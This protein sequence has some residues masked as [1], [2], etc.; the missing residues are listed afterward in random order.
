M[1]Q[2]I[3]EFI[4]NLVIYDYIL[5]GATFFLFILLIVLAI[6]LRGK[7]ALAMLSIL[8]AF[9][10]LILAPTLGYTQMHTFLYK[11]EAQIDSIKKLEFTPA[12]VINGTYTNHSNF[13]FTTCK[14]KAKVFKVATNEML[15]SIKN[16]LFPFNPF[17]KETIIVNKD[18]KPNESNTYKLIIEPFNYQKDY[19]VSVGISCR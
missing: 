7:M 1:K 2:Q 12:L 17:A 6:V 3:N 15:A 9:L 19:N 13:N 4:Q 8:M 10:V 11:T 14:I 18:I 5:F 16:S